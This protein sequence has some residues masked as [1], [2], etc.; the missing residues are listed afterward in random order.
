MSEVSPVNQLPPEI[1]AKIF[2]GVIY[3]GIELIH[4]NPYPW[5]LAL[6]CRLWRD[7]TFSTPR[8]WSNVDIQLESLPTQELD[9][10][11]G[12]LIA[13]W[14]L[15]LSRSGDYPLT[16]TLR[17]SPEGGAIVPMLLEPLVDHV[18][19]WDTMTFSI[20][21]DVLLPY[22][23]NPGTPYPCLRYLVLE[24]RGLLGASE[25]PPIQLFQNAPLLSQLG[26]HAFTYSPFSLKL[27]WFQITELASDMNIGLSIR[28]LLDS[29]QN[30]PNLSSL[31]YSQFIELFALPPPTTQSNRIVQLPYLRRLAMQTFL[32]NGTPFFEGTCAPQLSDIELTC[33]EK[34][35]DPEIMLRFLRRSNC[36]ITS[37]RLNATSSAMASSFLNLVSDVEVVTLD[38][39]PI[40]EDLVRALTFDVSKSSWVAPKLKVMVLLG[41][42][43]LKEEVYSA[44]ADM[45]RSR[46]Q[47]L[48][49]EKR[50]SKL[51]FLRI[52]EFD[53]SSEQVKEPLVSNILRQ[54]L[55]PESVVLFTREDAAI[56]TDV[57]SPSVANS[58]DTHPLEHGRHDGSYYPHETDPLLRYRDRIY[59]A[60]QTQTRRSRR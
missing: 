56:V 9:A 30:M 8:L 55:S 15:C 12:T 21:L 57:W 35:W 53:E 27:P 31:V 36:S 14:K 23:S 7:V 22:I 24:G 49:Q 47:V 40:D 52:K 26:L 32:S 11:G 33:T 48:P 37:L 28:G 38:G 45:I 6:V 29:L 44:F 50:G 3:E 58:W 42:T 1:L 10:G 19:R 5:R 2:V 25:P 43:N 60:S 34:H 17:G 54:R 39:V 16:V 46:L 4:V 20:P 18:H 13:A 51:D 41:T 59:Q